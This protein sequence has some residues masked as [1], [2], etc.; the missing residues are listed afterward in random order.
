MR[1]S[2]LFTSPSRLVDQEKYKYSYADIAKEALSANQLMI[3]LEDG[4][5]ILPFQSIKSIKI[6]PLPPTIPEYAV[7]NARIIG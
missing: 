3:E 5:L 6:S 2:R 7:R 4:L 1:I